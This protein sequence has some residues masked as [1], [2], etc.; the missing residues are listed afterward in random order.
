MEEIVAEPIVREV[1]QQ[2]RRMDDGSIEVLTVI[3]EVYAPG[4]FP[5]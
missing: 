5:E 1:E 3:R 4:D 2:T